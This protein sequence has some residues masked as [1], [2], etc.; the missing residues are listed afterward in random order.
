MNDQSTVEPVATPPQPT[1]KPVRP[2]RWLAGGLLGVALCAV[3]L[4]GTAFAQ[5]DSDG[6]NLRDSFVERLAEKL[7]LTTD[8]LD[9][10][11]DETTNEMIDN[12]VADGKLSEG[13][14]DALRER[15]R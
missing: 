3:L 10:A 4:G 5:D 2:R 15:Q 1:V 8:E 13:R 6:D 9:A 7:G 14:A 11:I 12:A